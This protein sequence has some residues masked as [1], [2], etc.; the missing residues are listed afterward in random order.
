MWL[1]EN[2]LNLSFRFLLLLLLLPFVGVPIFH[3]RRRVIPRL[4]FGRSE[5]RKYHESQNLSDNRNPERDSPTRYS[6]L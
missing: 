3:L 2:S 4:D 1:C 5:N 6:V